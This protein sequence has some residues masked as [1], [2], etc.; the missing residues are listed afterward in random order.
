MDKRFLSCAER[1]PDDHILTLCQKV[2]K[3]GAIFLTANEMLAGNV[4]IVQ[5]RA[6]HRNNIFVFTKLIF[7]S[8]LCTRFGKRAEK[9][10]ITC[11]DDSE[12]EK[13]EVVT[14]L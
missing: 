12:K 5:K 8:Y 2:T 4:S 14:A 11:R 1:L 6:I 10:G 13:K 7:F 9:F 3:D